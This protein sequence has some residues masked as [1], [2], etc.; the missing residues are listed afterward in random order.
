MNLLR[1]IVLCLMSVVVAQPVYSQVL[2]VPSKKKVVIDGKSYYLHTVKKDE[3]LYSISRAYNVLQRDIVFH[4]PD[5]LESV[6]LGQELK[7]PVNTGETPAVNI[8]Q[9]A[10]F[11]YH[12]TEKGQTVFWLTQH[13]NIS[14]EDLFKHNPVLE[15]SELQAGQVITIPKKTDDTAQPAKLKIA[16]EV[17]TV[18]RGETLFSIA[19]SYNADLNEIYELNPEIDPKDARVKMGQQIKIPLPDAQPIGLPVEI[20]KADTIIIRQ[21]LK[22]QDLETQDFLSQSSDC[23]ETSQREFRIAMLLPLFLADNAPASPPDSG[24]VVNSEGRF[25]YRDGR[26]W[27]HPRS[28]DALEFYQGALLAIDSLK[29]QG[30]NA[31]VVI[32][33]TMHDTLKIAQILRNPDMK[34]MDLII[35]PFYTDLVNQVASFARENRIHYV[36]PIAINEASLINNPYLMQ[37]NTGEI[38]TVTPM[39]EHISKQKNVHVTLI[40]NQLETDQIVFNAYLNKL[41]T[42]FADSSLTVLQ[43]RYDDLQEPDRY[44]KTER[45]NV[46]IIPAE[47]KR[48]VNLIAGKLYAATHSFQVNLY[49]PASWTKFVD[50][51]MEYLHTLEFRYAS[52][53]YIDYDNPQVQNFLQQYRKMYFTE[54]TMLTGINE[55]SPQAYQFAFLGYDVTFFFMSVMKKYGKDFGDCIPFFRM[56]TQQSDFRF[57]KINPFS[58]YK[59]TNLDIYKYGKDYSIMKEKVE[60]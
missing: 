3:T 20:S 6:R 10:Q 39:V 22:T 41:K 15:H 14:K 25:K 1:I 49:G 44:L 29:K 53:F 58:G 35:G 26:Y 7:I 16:H 5:A 31:D 38:N 47:N 60:N 37:V 55:I 46:V 59:N 27:I 36:S 51:D 32:F 2:V 30:L 34:N 8:L 19:K 24:M 33:D 45:M 43:M 4:N 50:L 23:A 12:I 48:F 52:A 18:K 57:E 9:S 11:I 54:P 17:Y 28:A 56:P 40:G 13:Y 21:D 42:I